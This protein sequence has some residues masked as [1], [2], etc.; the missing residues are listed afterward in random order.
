MSEYKAVVTVT[1]QDGRESVE[2]EVTVTTLAELFRACQG[3]PPS[4]LVRVQVNGPEGD[5]LLN[6]ASFLR[7]S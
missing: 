3:A 7:R 5:V 6:F 2:S 1:S 4:R